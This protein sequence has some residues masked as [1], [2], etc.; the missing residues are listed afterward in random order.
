MKYLLLLRHAKSSWKQPC[1]TDH[2]R[3]LNKRGKHDAPRMGD[4]LSREDLIPDLIISSSAERALMTAEA[5]AQSSGFVGDLVVDRSL[6]HG[7]TMDFISALNEVSDQVERVMMVG[8]NPG[9]EELLVDLVGS[10]ER[11]VTASLAHIALPVESWGRLDESIQGKL[12]NLWRPK[13]LAVG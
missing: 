8:H 2:E 1:L 10:Y 12:L 7:G 6:Y 3:P 5:A 4:L 11:M 9:M 13:D